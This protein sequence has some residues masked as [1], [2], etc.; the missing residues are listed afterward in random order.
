MTMSTVGNKD[1]DLTK[2]LIAELDSISKMLSKISVFDGFTPPFEHEFQQDFLKNNFLTVRVILFIGLILYASYS[3]VEIY[4]LPDWKTVVVIRLISVMPLLLIVLFI[5]FAKIYYRFQ[6]IISVLFAFIIILD[7]VTSAALVPVHYKDTYYLTLM[8]ISF[9]LTTLTTLQFKYTFMICVFMLLV[10]NVSYQFSGMSNT[11]YYSWGFIGDNYILLGASIVC[12]IASYYNEIKSRKTFIL[13][14]IVDVKSKLLEYLSQTDELT[15]LMN[16]RYLYENISSEWNRALRYH[17][18]LAVIFSDFDYFKEYNDI[19]GHQAGDK[20]LNSV[21]LVFSVCVNR[22]GDHVGRYGGDEFMAILS[23]TNFDQAIIVAKEIMEHIKQLSIE[24]RGSK[25]SNIISLTMGI[26]VLT[27][28]VKDL[29]NTL[30]KQ[31]DL[32]LQMGKIT[33]RDSIYIY[34]ENGIESVIPQMPET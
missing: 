27:P 3:F 32:A 28:G 4:T 23:N 16:R 18:P 30:I 5:N 34:T 31:A 6:Q 9:Y 17:Y 33:R 10:F 2:P 19:Y 13:N 22:S 26:A 8:L 1:S 7:L 24:H 15:G 21:G 11:P 14:K 25:I 20:A 12:L 29:Q